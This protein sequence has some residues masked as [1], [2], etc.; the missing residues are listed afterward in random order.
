MWLRPNK[1]V[2]RLALLLGAA[3]AVFSFMLISSFNDMLLSFRVF[4][5][6]EKDFWS[7]IDTGVGLS[8]MMGYSLSSGD[9]ALLQVARFRYLL[10]T[11]GLLGM[12]WSL[13]CHAV[14]RRDAGKRPALILYGLL[15]FILGVCLYTQSLFW[16]VIG[17]LLMV[18]GIVMALWGLVNAI[19]GRIS[20]DRAAPRPAAK[21]PERTVPRPKGWVMGDEDKFGVVQVKPREEGAAASPAP[22][23]A[24][25]RPAAP[26]RPV[27]ES[28]A[29]LYGKAKITGLRMAGK[30][31][32]SVGTL[33]EA[34][35]HAAD[36][37]SAKAPAQPAAP[38]QPPAEPKAA[39][40][41]RPAIHYSSTLNPSAAPEAAPPRPVPPA[42]ADSPSRR[43][44]LSRPE[45]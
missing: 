17:F 5:F 21:A 24:P 2:R 39:P 11:L 14:A 45:L 28:L 26:A 34:M 16:S 1:W 41:P 9:M 29:D 7:A 15:S 31:A 12:G 3:L 33:S 8:Q 19:R 23:A 6:S 37:G 44:G 27:G 32:E 20:P 36:H 42:S 4:G 18:A 25:P 40:R 38:A 22:K 43:Q 30:A 35:M 13:V 10:L